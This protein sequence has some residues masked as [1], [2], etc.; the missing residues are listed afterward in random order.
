MIA[1]SGSDVNDIPS[2]CN[3]VA[4]SNHE[5]HH[6]ITFTFD[7]S[8][9]RLPHKRLFPKVRDTIKQ[10][11][12]VTLRDIAERLDISISTVSRALGEDTGDMVAP[13]L[14]AKILEFARMVNY[15]PHP[16]AQLMRKP[17]RHLV[18][19]LMPLSTDSFISDYMNGILAGIV[20]A[21]SDMEMEARIALLDTNNSDILTQVRHAA[22]GAGSIVLVGQLLSPR[23]LV[24][25]EEVG[26]PIIV[27]DACLPP[28]MD[29]AEVAVSTVGMNNRQCCYDLTMELLK[30]GHRRLALINGPIHMHDAWERQQG[31]IKA[32]T[33]YRLLIDH[34]AIVHEP[35]TTD[36]GAR[37]LE[38][39]MQRSVNPTAIVCG[40]DEMAFGVL[41]K[42]T[43]QNI[44]CPTGISV[45]GFDDSRLAAR[46]SPSLTTVRQPTI[47]MGRT[48]V[49]MLN[50]RMLKP[51]TE[52]MAEHRVLSGE[53][54]RRNSV[55][56]PPDSN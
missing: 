28:S 31:Y 43:A 11:G 10:L 14:R 20:T 8:C 49:E 19:V 45:V 7:F 21:C 16:A 1:D 38:T 4:C 39:L 35:F 40:N 48:A 55:A 34:Q 44:A 52:V 25:L 56:P 54:V 13:E 6:G 18:T 33:E 2:L 53:I 23:Q 15:T 50:E 30:L 9:N 41:E 36:G 3:R 17:K 27:M 47:E 46:I 37:A 32:L 5:C 42:L 12:N 29:L 26:R 24:K 22:I 51:S